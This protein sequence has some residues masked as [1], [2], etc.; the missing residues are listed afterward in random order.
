MS[1]SKSQ[2]SIQDYAEAIFRRKWFFILPFV[3]ILAMGTIASFLL[4]KVYQSSIKIQ[5][6]SNPLTSGLAR[7]AGPESAIDA[8]REKIMSRSYLLKVIQELDLTKGGNDSLILE[9]V[10][11]NMRRHTKIWGVGRTVI[12]ISYESPNPR[13]SQKVVD[14]MTKLFI[15]ES[16][17]EQETETAG[18]IDFIQTQ[19]EIYRRKL[20][21]S[22]KV[23]AQFGIY[24]SKPGESGGVPY[25]ANSMIGQL[26]SKLIDLR[27]RLAE[28]L[29]DS[30]ESH[31]LVIE[32]RQA[33]ATTTRRI[34]EEVG[35]A[36]PNQVLTAT[37]SLKSGLGNIHY[38]ELEAAR[39]AREVRVNENLYNM[40]LKKL[41]ETRITQLLQMS[42]RR[43]KFR[44][45]D[46]AR[47]P[48]R[49][50]KR[51]KKKTVGFGFILG[52][53]IGIGSVSLVES[54]DHSFRGIEGASA[55]LDLPILGCIPKVVT[56]EER[57]KARRRT[58]ILT[59]VIIFFIWIVLA[60]VG[61]YL[62]R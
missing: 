12:Q 49:P 43:K 48:L 34:K 21:E 6:G 15:E 8:L 11:Q 56:D 19:L 47:V 41:E 10:I 42:E 3:S 37:E 24:E 36:N 54:A 51:N 20:E 9:E 23:L 25:R 60:G 45:L 16:L 32:L 14:T 52:M 28:L 40:L 2:P 59:S 35:K 5:V 39:L 26:N 27:K 22:E 53:L 30:K 62:A 18:A 17:S 55:F 7:H 46:P 38:H 1:E 58:I 57:R 13:T 4:P 61:V 33:I 50:I 31:P 29:V 44:I